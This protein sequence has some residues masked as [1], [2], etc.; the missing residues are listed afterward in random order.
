VGWGLTAMGFLAASLALMRMR[1][2]EFDLPPL[3]VAL[4]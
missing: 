4:R 3:R 1:D 2:D